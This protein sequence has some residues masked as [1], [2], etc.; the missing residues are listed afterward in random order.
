M[1]S[2]SASRWTT[3]AGTD[4]SR[5]RLRQRLQQPY[6]CRR[7]SAGLTPAKVAQSDHAAHLR[8]G[9]WQGRTSPRGVS[10]P[11]TEDPR[12]SVTHP[13]CRVTSSQDPC[14]F[15]RRVVALSR[16]RSLTAGGPGS[17]GD[18]TAALSGVPDEILARGGFDTRVGC[19]HSGAGKLDGG[20]ET[21]KGKSR[22]EVH[23]RCCS[24]WSS[25]SSWDSR[26]LSGHSRSA[27]RSVSSSAS[28]SVSRPIS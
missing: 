19:C 23:R 21:S 15:G 14:C 22:E 25:G 8:D 7:R 9:S 1:E 28:R 16:S 2:A 11:V 5:L 18:A 17:R 12:S 27:R 24:R 3:C 13:S 4:S 26:R 10:R 20:Q 6:R